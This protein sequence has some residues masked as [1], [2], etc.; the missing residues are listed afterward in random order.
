MI[1]HKENE[2]TFLATISYLQ[3]LQLA[4]SFETVDCLLLHGNSENCRA[5][6]LTP[7]WCTYR[8]VLSPTTNLCFNIDLWY[9]STPADETCKPFLTR[10][11]R[12]K[13]YVR[14]LHYASVFALVSM[15]LAFSL[16]N[17]F[18]PRITVLGTSEI[19][20]DWNVVT[21]KKTAET[22]TTEIFL[23]FLHSFCIKCGNLNGTTPFSSYPH[24]I[25]GASF[26]SIQNKTIET[27][28]TFLPP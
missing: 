12:Q 19:M 26:K 13:V 6:P 20:K 27:K 17:C 11:K 4:L 1:E 5:M 14:G 10:M 24:C 25:V 21:R 7:S 22:E 2:F 15:K 3:N 23:L 18:T 16:Q 8:G 28:S 9:R